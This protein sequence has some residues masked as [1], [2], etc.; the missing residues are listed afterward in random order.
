MA[1]VKIILQMPLRPVAFIRN[2][3]RHGV[4]L[5]K[6]KEVNYDWVQS[7]IGDV[8]IFATLCLCL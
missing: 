5:N 3:F 6:C 2:I 1:Y 8:I 4:Y 7:D